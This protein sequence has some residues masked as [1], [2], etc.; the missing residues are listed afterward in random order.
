MDEFLEA[1]T[2]FLLMAWQGEFHVEV[3]KVAEIKKV[4]HPDNK[5]APISSGRRGENTFQCKNLPK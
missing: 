1:P 5:T 4:F 3:V 2:C